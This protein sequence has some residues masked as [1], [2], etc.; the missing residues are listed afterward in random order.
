MWDKNVINSYVATM[1]IKGK[2]VVYANKSCVSCTWASTIHAIT[3]SLHRFEI[4][5][6]SLP[7]NKSSVCWEVVCLQLPGQYQTDEIEPNERSE[8][9]LLSVMGHKSPVFLKVITENQLLYVDVWEIHQNQ[10]TFEERCALFDGRFIGRF[11]GA[12]FSMLT[13]DNQI[14]R[15]DLFAI[16][17]TS[18]K[19]PLELLSA[20]VVSL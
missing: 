11:T 20:K 13:H 5:N 8:I 9:G 16:I 4:R 7:G 12:N 2:I 18:V 19:F 10:H 14:F 17:I 15:N 1:L 6:P 3:A